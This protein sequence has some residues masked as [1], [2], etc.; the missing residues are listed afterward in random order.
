MEKEER[1]GAILSVDEKLKGN[2]KLFPFSFLG[3]RLVSGVI[4]AGDRDQNAGDFLRR[5][6]STAGV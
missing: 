6:V 2:R 1:I 3:K 4:D 5:A